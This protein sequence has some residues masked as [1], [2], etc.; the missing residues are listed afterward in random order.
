MKC[1]AIEKMGILL[2]GCDQCDFFNECEIGKLVEKLW[3]EGKLK[4]EYPEGMP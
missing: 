1:R 4:K 3:S 2:E